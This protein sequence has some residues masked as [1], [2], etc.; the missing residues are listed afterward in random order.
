MNLD[1]YLDTT[2]SLAFFGDAKI[3]GSLE[4]LINW[5][6]IRHPI[7]RIAYRVVGLLV[8]VLSFLIPLWVAQTNEGLALLSGII[9]LVVSSATFYSFKHGWSGF[10]LA[11]YKLKV[12]K[13]VYQEAII[14]ARL[15][16]KEQGSEEEALKLA[17]NETKSLMKDAAEVVSSE[18]EGYFKS[19]SLPSIPKVVSG[20]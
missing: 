2:K 17:V 1:E 19:T 15:L 9:T 20:K 18:A 3:K 14:R 10:Y 6:A 16:Q 8:V 7:Y 4:Y 12:L 13:E 11:E 5:Y